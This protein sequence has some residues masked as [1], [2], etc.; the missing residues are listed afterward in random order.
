MTMSVDS[1]VTMRNVIEDLHD[2]ITFERQRLER[3]MC[4]AIC[5]ILAE[6]ETDRV[7]YIK[8]LMS[9]HPNMSEVFKNLDIE[10]PPKVMDLLNLEKL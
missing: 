7:R 3:I 4:I 2:E 5:G 10:I 9:L 6:N 1:A 8:H